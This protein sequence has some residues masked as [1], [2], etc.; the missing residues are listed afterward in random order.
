MAYTHH[1]SLGAIKGTVMQIYGFPNHRTQPKYYTKHCQEPNPM[2]LDTTR[3]AWVSLQLLLLY[4][5]H[6]SFTR[7]LLC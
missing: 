1:I 4:K 6:G 2:T 7:P 3:K 5:E